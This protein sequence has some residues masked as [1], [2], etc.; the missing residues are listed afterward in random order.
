MLL[1]I[2]EHKSGR[3]SIKFNLLFPQNAIIT[4]EY[5]LIFHARKPYFMPDNE[6]E[7]NR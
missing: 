5:A 2:K 6:N 1:K 4:G 3:F 7:S